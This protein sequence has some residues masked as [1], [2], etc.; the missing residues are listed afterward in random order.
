MPRH[1][2]ILGKPKLDTHTLFLIVTSNQ[3]ENENE[4]GAIAALLKCITLDPYNLKALMMLGVRFISN[5]DLSDSLY[6]IAIQTT[7]KKV[8]P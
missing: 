8:V 4:P 3:A 7:L 1:G 2:V 6:Y 5:F